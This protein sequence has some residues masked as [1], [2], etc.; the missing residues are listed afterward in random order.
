MFVSLRE[1]VICRELV[2]K[3]WA[4]YEHPLLI[5]MFCFDPRYRVVVQMFPINQ[6]EGRGFSVHDK[7]AFKCS[8][9]IFCE[10]KFFFTSYILI[11]L[12][13]YPSSS[14]EITLMII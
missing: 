1:N 3:R 4:Q 14:A 13:I 6:D 7:A 11:T 12:Y 9:G 5:L 2:E 10:S 8:S